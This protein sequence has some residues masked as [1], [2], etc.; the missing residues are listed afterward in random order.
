MKKRDTSNDS[1][2]SGTLC[3]ECGGPTLLLNAGSIW[4]PAE[5]PHPGGHFV[6]RVAFERTPAKQAAFDAKARAEG[7]KVVTV[8]RVTR[9]DAPPVP[10]K[11]IASPFGGGM[12]DFIGE[13]K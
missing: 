6:K 7:R 4:C 3:D 5:D 2:Y 13:G 12:D 11:P 10:P 9:A 8:S 1:M